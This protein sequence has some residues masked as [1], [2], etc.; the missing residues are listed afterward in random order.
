MIEFAIGVSILTASFAGAFTYGYTFYR[1]NTLLN[2]VSAGARYASLAQWDSVTQNASSTFET[3]IKNVV[4]YGN[5]NG[6]TEPVVAGLTTSNVV[7]TPITVRSG[8][9]TIY[10]PTHMRVSINGFSLSAIF[11]TITFNNKPRVEYPYQGLLTP[12]AGGN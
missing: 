9:S 7:L 12:V 2:A 1:Y 6:G 8:T 11:Q 5:P 10:V 4:V 3:Q